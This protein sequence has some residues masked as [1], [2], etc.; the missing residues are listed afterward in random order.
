MTDTDTPNGQSTVDEVQH[1]ETSL[2]PADAPI[3]T[4]W[5]VIGYDSTP[6]AEPTR[7]IHVGP[8]DDRTKALATRIAEL[9]TANA[10]E[11]E[12]GGA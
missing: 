1:W 11:V 4:G 2:V 8:S 10:A 6:G 7:T 3:P 5:Y 9:L 12:S